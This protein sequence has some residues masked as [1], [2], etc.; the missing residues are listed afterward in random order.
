ME[1]VNGKC[2]DVLAS[3]TTVE[4]SFPHAAGSCL[5]VF[6]AMAAVYASVAPHASNELRRWVNKGCRWTTQ[7]VP[8]DLA[9]GTDG[10]NKGCRLTQ[11][12]V[13][14]DPARVN[15]NLSCQTVSNTAMAVEPDKGS[16]QRFAREP[17]LFMLC[18]QSEAFD[19]QA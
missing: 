13:S 8:I 1:S 5:A 9:R 15:V 14:I 2:L 16:A 4:R 18:R 10:P 12:G 6:A 3:S 17:Q 11:Q 7:G 19:A